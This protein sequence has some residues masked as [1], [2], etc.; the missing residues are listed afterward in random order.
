MTETA[1]EH[2]SVEIII[3]IVASGLLVESSSG[4]SRKPKAPEVRKENMKRYCKNVDIKDVQFIE[5]CILKWIKGKT[6]RED[7]RKLLA[8]YSS[9]SKRQIEAIVEDTINMYTWINPIIHDIAVDVS[10]RIQN[11]KLDLPPI[12]YKMKYDDGSRKW[13]RIGIQKPMHQIMDYIAV[14]ACEELFLAK[15]GRYQMASLPG[16]GQ[17]KGAAT[18]QRW[19]QTDESHTR[20]YAQAD[21]KK[22]YPSIDHCKLK[23]VFARDIK[24]P[25]LIWLINELIDCFD[26][27]LSI[28]SYFSQWACNYYLSSAYHYATEN[29]Y[30]IKSRRGKTERTRLVY[31]VMFY[32]DDILFLGSSKKDVEAA[33]NLFAM[34]IQDS[35]GL[36]I[37][38]GWILRN[39]DYIKNGTRRGSYIDMM[40]YRIYRDHITIRRRTYKRIR[41]TMIRVYQKITSGMVLLIETAYRALS[42]C[43]KVQHTDCAKIWKKYSIGKIKSFA[44][45]AISNHDKMVAEKRRRRLHE[46]RNSSFAGAAGRDYLQPASQQDSGMLDP[47]EYQ[48]GSCPF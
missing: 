39:V 19:I 4:V 48:G 32:M 41:R 42:Y 11:R 13:R 31:H 2:L 33:M 24:N 28:G 23:S 36:S 1:P 40:G 27:G 17:E 16:R 21:I 10:N 12:R 22:C 6:K 20:Y 47:E 15:I 14:G 8:N 37:K 34:Y 35:L 44:C 18:I 29:L 43:A 5:G 9:Y 25:E 45:K 7:V 30:K 46:N 38:P 26:D 3:G